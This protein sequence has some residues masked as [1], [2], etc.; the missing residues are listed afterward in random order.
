MNKLLFF[1]INIVFI[2]TSDAAST[3]PGLPTQVSF[4]VMV[5]QHLIFAEQTSLKTFL[6]ALDSLRKKKSFSIRIISAKNDS[7]H[8]YYHSDTLFRASTGK[9]TEY[10][11]CKYEA[12][13]KRFLISGSVNYKKKTKLSDI[14]HIYGHNSEISTQI[15]I[16]LEK[17]SAIKHLKE[18][19]E[20][21]E[22]HPST[23]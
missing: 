9:I 5:N 2:A 7:R 6:T 4:T 20:K 19:L 23:Y 13:D 22:L 15:I 3:C 1:L 12:N 8:E 11:E 18:S 14:V 16:T 10:S 17:Q 21:S